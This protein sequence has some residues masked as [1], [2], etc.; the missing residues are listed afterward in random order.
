[1]YTARPATSDP[2]TNVGPSQYSV[3]AALTERAS[4][5]P[6]WSKADRFESQDKV[7]ISKRHVRSKLGLN[8]PGPKYAPT[9]YDISTNLRQSGKPANIP[10]GK[11]CP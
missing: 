2:H 6:V 10:A 9:N 7:F 5:R 3:K 4:P 1:M 8:S 11:W